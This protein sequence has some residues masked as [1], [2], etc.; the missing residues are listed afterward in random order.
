MLTDIQTCLTSISLQA[1]SQ[2]QKI[3]H[4]TQA[5]P[6][7][8]KWRGLE[9]SVGAATEDISISRWTDAQDVTRYAEA[10]TPANRYFI[11]IALKATRLKLTR[12]RQTIFDGIMPTGTLYVSA[13]SKQLSAQFH[14]PC[15]FLHFHVSP[16]YF[17]SQQLA[18]Q[19]AALDP[20]AMTPRDALAALYEL[21]KLLDR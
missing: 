2:E 5:L 13:P 7:E 11:A 1:S 4:R 6:P 19:L 20:D 10:T 12:G 9:R 16:N 15:D 14:A 3:L 18:T 8:W 17:P 21:R